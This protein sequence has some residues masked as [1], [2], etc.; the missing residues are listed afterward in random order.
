MTESMQSK[1]GKK[2]T[3][4]PSFVHRNVPFNG[5]QKTAQVVDLPRK[6]HCPSKANLRVKREGT[7]P[8][9]A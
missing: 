2:W 3:T 9:K 5:H 6:A 1:G 8:G 4:V 7:L